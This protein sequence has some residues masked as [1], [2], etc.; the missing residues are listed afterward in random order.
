VYQS[1]FHVSHQ[2]RPPGKGNALA[3][4]L[5]FDPL[6]AGFD[7]ALRTVKEHHEK[8]DYIHQN[9]VRAGLVERAEDWPW[10]S[11]REYSGT[12]RAPASVHPILR[13]DR[14]LLPADERARI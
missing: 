13:I 10:S 4:A 5:P 3:T 1:E 8:V 2:R 6:R 9:P 14:I 7:R 12:L 11:V